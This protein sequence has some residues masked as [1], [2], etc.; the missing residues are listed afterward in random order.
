MATLEFDDGT[1]L[2][3]RAVFDAYFKALVLFAERYVQCREEGESIVQDTFVALW[4]KQQQFENGQAAKAWLYTTVKNKAL[5]L[6]R[7]QKLHLDYTT[8]QLR[9]KEREEYFM[10]SLIQEETRRLL[11]TAID[12]LPEQ[13]R[14]V[15]LLNL[16]GMDNT[17]IAEVMC[18]SPDTVKFHKKNAY[19]F[20][21][22]K[23][24]GYFYLLFI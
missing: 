12:A 4:E 21:R 14:R 16:E 5:N 13:C 6:L 8:S 24:K 11:F 22:E 23:L 10:K 2:N 17:K 20:L 1:Q 15:C 19:R 3:F 7:H 18:I 9:E